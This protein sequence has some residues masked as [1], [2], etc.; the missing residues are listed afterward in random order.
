M[1]VEPEALF[2][3]SLQEFIDAGHK[4]VLARS[5]A[6][7]SRI[8]KMFHERHEHVGVYVTPHKDLPRGHRLT[9]TS[10]HKVLQVLNDGH[11][12]LVW[13]APRARRAEGGRDGVVEQ[14]DDLVD[15]LLELGESQMP[16]GQDTT[17]TWCIVVIDEVHNFTE[18]TG[19]PGPV[20]RLLAEGR[21][22]GIRVICVS[23]RPAR[24]SLE[25][26]GQA[27]YVIILELNPPDE[28]YL[29]LAGYP[30]DEFR[31]L[32]AWPKGRYW[33]VLMQKDRWCLFRA[34]ED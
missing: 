32:T 9:S 14:L 5:G 2:Q 15:A 17:P 30:I 4:A 1:R 20:E 12:K 10:Q 6:G 26:L 16:A 21:K 31:E 19:Y 34:L 27:E 33:F 7:K 28:K 29:R 23:Q 13:K 11:R 25:V 18:K 8:V 24:V 3:G 22:F